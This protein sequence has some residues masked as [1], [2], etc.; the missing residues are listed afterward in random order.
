M[1]ALLKGMTNEAHFDGKITTWKLGGEDRMAS[2]LNFPS[3]A[4]QTGGIRGD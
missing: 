4:S 2:S 3:E 1:Y